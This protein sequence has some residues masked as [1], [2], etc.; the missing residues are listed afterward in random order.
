MA[1]LYTHVEVLQGPADAVWTESELYV[2][3]LCSWCGERVVPAVPV[4]VTDVA[5]L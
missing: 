5:P 2:E 4:T 1:N 3:Y